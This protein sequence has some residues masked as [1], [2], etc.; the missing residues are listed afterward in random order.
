MQEQAFTLLR[1]GTDLFVSAG[2]G[3]GK[4]AVF[5]HAVHLTRSQIPAGLP[6][7]I[8]VYLAPTKALAQQKYD[9]WQ[10]PNHPW[11]Q[12][13]KALV[14]GD[15]SDDPGREEAIGRAEIIC[16][17]PESLLSRV[18]KHE[19]KGHWV[20]KVTLVGFDEIHTI[21][22]E[23]RGGT[24]ENLLISIAAHFPRARVLG[25]SGTF[26]NMEAFSAWWKSLGRKC[27]TLTSDYRAVPIEHIYEHASKTVAA[28]ALNALRHVDV[29]SEVTLIGVWSKAVG[30]R[31]HES[32]ALSLGEHKTA[33]HCAD[34]NRQ[35]RADVE[36]RLQA[37]DLSV[38]V[39]TST[40]FV[41]INSPVDTVI[42]SAVETPYGPLSV[43]EIMQAAG[44]AGRKGYGKDK[45]KVVF[46]VPKD[47]ESTLRRLVKEGETILSA[48]HSA[49]VLATHVL[50]NVWKGEIRTLK[51]AQAWGEKTFAASQMT[52]A[53]R[54]DLESET[55]P[56]QFPRPV[57]FNLAS[58]IAKLLDRRFLKVDD[59]GNISCTTKGS[60]CAFYMLDPYQFDTL[61]GN[62]DHEAPN[63]R[64]SPA[65]YARIWGA[66]PGMESY[67]SQAQEAYA[68]VLVGRQYKPA[69][70]AIED[71]L[72]AGRTPHKRCENL[73]RTHRNDA[74]RLLTAVFSLIHRGAFLRDMPPQDRHLFLSDMVARHLHMMRGGYGAY[75]THRAKVN[76]FDLESLVACGAMGVFGSD[77]AAGN[78]KAQAVLSIRTKSQLRSAPT[79]S[80]APKTTAPS[81]LSATAREAIKR[82]LKD[83]K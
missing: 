69:V 25:L 15:T 21:G 50:Y 77:Q 56:Q 44:R 72:T 23:S 18:M 14:T 61:L 2:T 30:R 68:G 31:I 38:V 10:D 74:P 58:A 39:C 5:H 9:E 67:D 63:T 57:A 3:T 45:G 24:I 53:V 20:K 79:T 27:H 71:A 76:A 70:G 16:M 54:K 29:Q 26:K 82:R 64:V 59:A 11:G 13:P 60:V 7:G 43:S 47:W 17:T 12:I 19:T 40:L 33:F 6:Q 46:V 41:G 55:Y 37:G 49:G 51:D 35:E 66:L 32:L 80:F 52:D 28:G 4:S 73:L 1:K 42:I 62:I 75:G 48:F 83:K 81:S 65:T 22:S 34:L 78:S 8:C 36:R